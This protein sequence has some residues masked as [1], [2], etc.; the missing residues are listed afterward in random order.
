[1]IIL[2]FDTSNAYSSVAISHNGEILYGYKET[3]PNKQAENL[4]PEIEKALDSA[5]LTYK[6]INYLAVSAGPGSFTGIR[7]A[8]ATAHGIILSSPNI[9][10]VQVTNFQTL[11][12]RIRQQYM[13]FD[14]AVTIVN[15]YRN[16]FYVE[17]FTKKDIYKKAALYSLEETKNIINN[18]DGKKVVAG[19]GIHQIFNVST[20]FEKDIIIL[21]RFAYPDAR[22]IC[23]VAYSDILK[24]IENNNLSPL[25]IR[26][27]D[28]KLP[29]QFIIN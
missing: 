26:P 8:L 1:M 29:D 3:T 25:Y 6:D 21:P 16:Q 24:G 9:N 20:N 11:N 12:F 14:Y 15:A 28:A 4:I 2:G 7:I 18:L 13:N 5:D 27:P 19:S 10:P 22:F 17:I 23:K